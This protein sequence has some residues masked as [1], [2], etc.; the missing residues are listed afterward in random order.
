MK[1][2][3]MPG[4]RFFLRSETHEQELRVIRS[5]MALW[6]WDK[7]SLADRYEVTEN[8]MRDVLGGIKSSKDIYLKLEADFDV[9]L[10]KE[11][12]TAGT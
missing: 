5:K 8:F 6:G 7:A 11:L 2:R 4:E 12:A 9:Q 10:F 1:R 3:F